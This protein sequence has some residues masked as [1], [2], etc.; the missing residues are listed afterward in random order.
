MAS[1][2]SGNRFSVVFG[3]GSF[4]DDSPEYA[5]QIA[6]GGRSWNDFGHQPQVVISIRGKVRKSVVVEG[7]VGFLSGAASGA[8]TLEEVLGEAPGLVIPANPDKHRFF[9]MLRDSQAYRTVVQALGPDEASEALQAA[10]DLVALGEFDPTAQILEVAPATEVFAMS[11]VRNTESFF[12][13]KNAGS[14]LR[15]LETETLG[16]LSDRLSVRFLLPG[17]ENEHQLDFRFDHTGVLP[18]RMAVVIGKNGVGKSQTLGRLARAALKGGNELTDANGV[19]PTISRLLAFAPTNEAESVFPSDR[20]RRPRIRYHRFSLNRSR[21]SRR[22]EYVGDLVVQLARSDESIGGLDRWTIFLNSMA[23][24]GNP[25]E[26]CLP[27]NNSERLYEPIVRLRDGN[28]AAFLRRFASVEMRK[29]PVRLIE[30]QGLPLSSGEISFVKFAAQVS[31]HIENGSL[32]LLDEPETHLHPNFISRFVKLLDGLLEQTGSVAI[33]ATHSAYFV[34]EVFTEQVTVLRVDENR[35]VSTEKPRLRTFGSD[36]GE[37][38]VFVFG[39]EDQSAH[40]IELKRRLLSKNLPWSEIYQQFSD[41][42]STE[43]LN[44]LRASIE[45]RGGL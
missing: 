16:Q 11:F 34:R 39:E 24:L 31:L 30:T 33:I 37:I 1:S 35:F 36:V 25:E 13:Y 41:E 2:E 10:R 44:D 15:G 43:F 21:R 38:S 40:A 4:A 18:K 12:A 23:A 8:S 14:I 27:S 29:E 22:N 7:F 3:D 19:G 28:E 6:P 42:L 26:I 32:I 20:L 17:H 5:I 45:E 9:T